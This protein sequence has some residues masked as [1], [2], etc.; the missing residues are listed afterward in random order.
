MRSALRILNEG[1]LKSG[2]IIL[3]N[4]FIAVF[5]VMF[6]DRPHSHIASISATRSFDKEQITDLGYG[7]IIF[8]MLCSFT[9]DT[10]GS[11]I[12]CMDGLLNR[13]RG[14]AF[15]FFICL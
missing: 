8:E 1:I 11:F 10:N 3:N 15:G 6:S 2:L 4:F 9:S 5:V 13:E 14:H 7:I 12:N